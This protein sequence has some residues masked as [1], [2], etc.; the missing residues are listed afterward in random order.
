M[1]RAK[2]TAT[3]TGHLRFVATEL[4]KGIGMGKR[5]QVREELKDKAE[6]LTSAQEAVSKPGA[7][8]RDRSDLKMIEQDFQAQQQKA[9]R[10]AR[11]GEARKKPPASASEKLERKLDDALA[12]SF[13]GSDPVSFIEPTN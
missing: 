9:E 10:L 2:A 4:S 8:E 7:S 12:D 5:R 11:R 6:K 13:P 3:E 1:Q